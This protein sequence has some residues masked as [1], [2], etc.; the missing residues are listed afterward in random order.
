MKAHD[1]LPLQS[2]EPQPRKGAV[3]AGVVVHGDGDEVG[4]AVG[5]PV[6]NDVVGPAVG[7]AVV[8]FMVGMAVGCVV[9]DAVGKRVRGA[10]RQLT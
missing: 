8:G 10:Y 1:P 3:G 9:G 6:G 5:A 7:S 4:D 2:P